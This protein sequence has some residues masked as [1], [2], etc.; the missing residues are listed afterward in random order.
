MDIRIRTT[1]P[2]HH[3]TKK[4]IRRIGKGGAYS[5][6]CLWSYIGENH[7]KGDI[8]SLSNEDITIAAGW[9]DNPDDFVNALIEVGFID[10]DITEDGK[11]TRTIHNWAEH[12]PYVFYSQERSEIARQNVQKRWN[13]NQGKETP[14][15]DSYTNGIQTEYQSDT[16]SPSHKKK[17]IRVKPLI[18][19]FLSL[20]KDVHD[21][22]PSLEG[23]KDG[24]AIKRTLEKYSP[25]QIE[26]IFDFYLKSEKAIKNGLSIAVALSNHS[27][28][29]YETKGKW[30]YEG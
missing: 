24:S 9:E 28:N 5:L 17:D 6:I 18:D 14:K 30:K 13:K 3:K 15:Y 16:P 25:Q 23:K 8:S 22:E 4:L 29:E 11:T 10:E 7:P 19:I 2:H 20:C 1:F 21:K 12:N 27:V 26:N